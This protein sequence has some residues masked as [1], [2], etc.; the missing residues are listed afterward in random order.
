MDKFQP[1][2]KKFKLNLNQFCDT[3]IPHPSLQLKTSEGKANDSES[4]PAQFSIVGQFECCGLTRERELERPVDWSEAGAS[5]PLMRR[6]PI[7]GSRHA[8]FPSWPGWRLLAEPE[9]AILPPASLA[10]CG[11]ESF[12]CGGAVAFL[13]PA[14]RPTPL[15]LF[16][17]IH[18][19]WKS[20][21]RTE[22]DTHIQ[23]NVEL[24]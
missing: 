20:T 2:L 15:H 16:T 7:P 11:Q 8:I 18:R 13:V 19:I 21:S 17:H 3:F 14:C 22:M 9:P 10:R 1:W 6:R 4:V 23:C 5:W 24:N 12:T